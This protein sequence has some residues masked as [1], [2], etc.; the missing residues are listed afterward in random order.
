MNNEL[1]QLKSSDTVMLL[2]IFVVCWNVYVKVIAADSN[3]INS[4]RGNTAYM[5]TFSQ[6]LSPEKS[7]PWQTLSLD[8]FCASKF[9]WS[10][11]QPRGNLNQQICAVNRSSQ[12]RSWPFELL[13]KKVN[14]KWFQLTLQESWYTIYYVQNT[15]EYL[16]QMVTDS[17]SSLA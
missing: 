7:W 14:Q 8:L 9:L 10:I 16:S 15:I 2:Q 6:C 3:I 17:I 5:Q 12:I 13:K 11:H 4:N 1:C